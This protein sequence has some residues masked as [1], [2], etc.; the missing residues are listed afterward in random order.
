MQE[1]GACVFLGFYSSIGLEV[2]ASRYV[3]H[4]LAAFSIQSAIHQ[5][6]FWL[7]SFTEREII[8]SC[9]I[10]SFLTFP[11]NI[12]IVLGNPQ[13][14]WT[15]FLQHLYSLGE[16]PT[17]WVCFFQYSHDALCHTCYFDNQIKQW[18]KMCWVNYNRLRCIAHLPLEVPG[19]ARG[20]GVI[21]LQ[22][23]YISGRLSQRTESNSRPLDWVCEWRMPF[24]FLK[25]C[26]KQM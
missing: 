24:T 2:P 22:W 25:D 4:R 10:C 9:K 13:P 17:C 20:G 1:V 3:D 6:F 12:S 14:I 7:K 26:K 8:I 16:V 21:S 23:A 18:S 5:Y 19:W 15:C 11:L